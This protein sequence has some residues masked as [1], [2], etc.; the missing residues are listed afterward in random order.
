MSHRLSQEEFV[1]KVKDIYD[2]EFDVIDTYVD[3]KTPLNF[4]HK[5]C[6][7]II[8]RI[9]NNVLSHKNMSCPVCNGCCAMEAI[10]GVTDL[11]SLR[12]DVAELLENP[13]DGYRHTVHSG[14]KVNFICPYCNN[15]LNKTIAKVSDRGLS[16]S[17][18]GKTKSYP[19]KFMCNLLD[20]LGVKFKTEYKI[21]GY[22]YRYDLYFIINNNSYVIEMDGG[23]GHGNKTYSGKVDKVG[24][25][26]DLIKDDICKRNNIKVIRID[27][28]YKHKN[29]FGYIVK[30]IKESELS[31]MFDLSKIDFNAIDITSS[32]STLGSVVDLWN[33]GVRSYDEFKKELHIPRPTIRRYLQEASIKGILSERYEDILKEIRMASNKKLQT[34]KG[35]HIICVE[36]NQV[37]VSIAEATRMT[38]IVSIQRVVDKADRHAGKLP[39]G[40][41]L[42]WKSL[43][44]N[45]YEKLVG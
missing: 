42:T 5:K 40:T 18:C 3:A 23:I 11:W 31:I 10:K 6:G 38:G 16:C 13:E 8:K 33:N 9:P 19:N 20:E 28:N 4:K 29:R 35:K 2:D 26:T 27:C 32:I 12:P 25:K 17:Y 15:V 39:D 1:S 36:T 22:D 41:K 44:R 14:K 30:H 7:T 45:E 43:T 24:L 21:D 34:S 37:Y